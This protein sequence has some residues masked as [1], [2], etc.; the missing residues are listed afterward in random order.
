M[1][2]LLFVLFAAVLLAPAALAK[3]PSEA[4][5]TGPGLGKTI[6]FKGSGEA[7]GSPLGD[8]TQY[9]GFFPA[10]FGQSPDPMLKGRPTGKLGPKFTIR[11]VVPDGNS[12]GA[13]LTQDLYPYASGGAVT[14][15]KPGQ[16]IFTGRS[17]GGWFR[18]GN[19]L[20]RTL[21]EA[22][23]PASPPRAGGGIDW[24]PP[25]WL[26]AVAGGLLLLGA[27]SLVLRRLRVAAPA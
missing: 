26:L 23:L 24:T 25:T 10:L 22:G 15:L 27:S 4:A 8:L 5:I 1:K 20:K 16:P 11:Y 13:R 19:E 18:G 2:R 17:L 9:T 14:Y 21:V 6:S 7:S 3:G 12:A